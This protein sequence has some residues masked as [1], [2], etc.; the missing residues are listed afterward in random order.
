LQATSPTRYRPTLFP[1]RDHDSRQALT[2]ITQFVGTERTY[3]H[4]CRLA[5]RDGYAVEVGG[6]DDLAVVAGGRVAQQLRRRVA[7]V[8]PGEV[9]EDQ[10]AGTRR[11]GDSTCSSK[12]WGQ[13][14][15]LPAALK[16]Q[17]RRAAH[18]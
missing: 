5:G 15:L 13:D 1:P 16:A 2:A 8:T 14:D 4:D 7:V 17:V 18:L 3:D 10:A 9:G 6:Q 11:G 12:D